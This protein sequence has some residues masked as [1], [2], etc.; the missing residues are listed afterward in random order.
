MIYVYCVIG[1][2]GI[3][4]LIYTTRVYIKRRAVRI[5][6]QV[7]RENTICKN[8]VVCNNC[9]HY[10]KFLSFGPRC[11]KT[12]TDIYNINSA[13]KCEHFEPYTSCN[14][15]Y[16]CEMEIIVFDS[17]KS[18][19]DVCYERLLSCTY[20]I[21]YQRAI[22]NNFDYCKYHCM[23]LKYGLK[24]PCTNFQPK[25]RCTNCDECI[26]IAHRYKLK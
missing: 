18:N 24:L 2:I 4:G 19:L 25:I 6:L 13:Y 21:Y 23:N 17:I 1:V 11:C 15:C 10:I 7:C 16:K 20:C 22:Q 8:A 5:K 12:H 26:N 9:R 14:Y 3:I